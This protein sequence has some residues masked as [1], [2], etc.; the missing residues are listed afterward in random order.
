MNDG[1][2]ICKMVSN[3]AEVDDSVG[4]TMKTLIEQKCELKTNPNGHR[5]ANRG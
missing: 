1:I 2:F 5:V 4:E 3:H